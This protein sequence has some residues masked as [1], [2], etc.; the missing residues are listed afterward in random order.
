MDADESLRVVVDKLKSPN[1]VQS[2]FVHP[3]ED[4]R[5]CTR[6]REREREREKERKIWHD[7][8]WYLLPP[9]LTED[10]LTVASMLAL[11]ILVRSGP[12]QQLT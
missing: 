10:K 6:K 5:G 9:V 7:M 12:D 3:Q 2:D 11:K 4:L 1:L 8:A